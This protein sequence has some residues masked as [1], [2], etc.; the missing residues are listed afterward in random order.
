MPDIGELKPNFSRTYIYGNPN[1]YSGPG[2]WRLT[3]LPGTVAPDADTLKD[4]FTVLPINKTWNGTNVNLFFDIE[5]L[6]TT[7]AVSV[8]KSFLHRML[9]GWKQADN[10]PERVL[11][12]G[13]KDLVGIDPI[14]ANVDAGIGTIWFDIS[15]LP[16]A[17]TTFRSG[18]RYRFTTMSFSYNSRSVDTLTASAPLE[19]QTSGDTATITFD[20]R[21]LPDV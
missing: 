4:I 16:S 17:M 13:L 21:T 19:S 20:L 8:D 14:N 7:K 11:R 15:N 10:P 3:N 5:N 9:N 6:G 18:R 1:P 2:A 12:S